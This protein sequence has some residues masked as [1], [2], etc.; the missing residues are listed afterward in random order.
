MAMLKHKPIIILALFILLLVKCFRDFPRATLLSGWVTA[1]DVPFPNLCLTVAVG[2]KEET[3]STCDLVVLTNDSCFSDGIGI[4][5]LVV[6]LLLGRCL[7]DWLEITTFPP[8]C[9][10]VVSDG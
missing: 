1:L 6:W 8:G 3:L 4:V 9:I 2:V 7:A 5:V 10:V